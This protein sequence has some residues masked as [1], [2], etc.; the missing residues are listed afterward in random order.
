MSFAPQV[1]EGIERNERVG[2]EGASAGLSTAGTVAIVS[3]DRR[4]CQLVAHFAAEA[5]SGDGHTRPLAGV[6]YQARRIRG[7]ISWHTP[8][9]EP[10]AEAKKQDKLLFTYFTRSYAY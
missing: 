5:A 1:A 3:P 7:L 6:R 4:L 10:L 9:P 8:R 2:C